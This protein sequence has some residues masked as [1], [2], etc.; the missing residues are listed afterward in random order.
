MSRQRE[1]AFQ[2]HIIDS[3]KH[4]GGLAKKWATEMQKGN[5]DLICS[6]DGYGAHFA[7]V[8]HIPDFESKRVIKNPMR[9]KQVQ[10]CRDFIKAGSNVLLYVVSGTDTLNSKLY[11]FDPMQEH[12]Y[13]EVACAAP[14][15]KGEKYDIRLVLYQYALMHG[16]K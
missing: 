1:L 10:V 3:Y 6:I 7:E 16:W 8:K 9:P 11:V 12:I 15:V 13:H 4:Q 5:P 2:N 14:Y